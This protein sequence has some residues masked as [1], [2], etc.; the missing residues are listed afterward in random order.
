[1]ADNR[2][3]PQDISGSF[4][5][6]DL[7]CISCNRVLD[8]CRD[9]DC[10]ED[11]RVFLTCFGQELI[12]KSS[13]VRVKCAN[14]VWTAIT[15]EPIQFNRGFYQIYIRFY[16]KLILEVCVTPGRPQEIEGI[17]VCDKQVILYGS[18]GFVNIF[19]SDVCNSDFCSLPENEQ[20]SNNLPTAVCEVVDP[21][22]LGVRVACEPK[23]C[24]CCCCCSVEEIPE[25]VCRFLGG[26][27]TDTYD[28]RKKL[29]VTLGFFSVVR[30]ERPAQF[31][32]CATEYSVPE[33][34]C[35]SNEEKNPCALFKQMDFPVNE[36]S[37][38][39]YRQLAGES[40]TCDNIKGSGGRRC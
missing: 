32:V 12:E 34:A 20:L 21:V 22:S 13:N 25:N 31:L 39:T 4:A 27:L 26:A 23:C 37:P 28:D 38:P 30:I 29:Y 35:V 33:K 36:F 7:V 8:S 9:K 2:N 6:K 1:M 11:Q 10:F 19:K 14:V 18:E 15:V 24:D 3:C 40:N 16:V 5:A 17:C